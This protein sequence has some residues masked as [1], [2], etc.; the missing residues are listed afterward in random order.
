MFITD[1][2]RG[3]G[4]DYPYNCGLDSRYPHGNTIRLYWYGVNDC[5]GYQIQMALPIKVANGA[6]A[7]ANVQGTPDLLLDTIVGPDKLDL[8]IE[9]LQYKTDYRFAIR[10]LDERDAN[11]KGDPNS[12]AHASNWFGHGNGR[13]W[14]EFM[15]IQ[16]KDR[17]ATPTAIFVNQSLTTE[18]TIT[19]GINSH[20]MDMVGALAEVSGIAEYNAEYVAA[21]KAKAK[22]DA[23]AGT[24]LTYDRLIAE[25]P[26]LPSTRPR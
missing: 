13:Q 21:A 7:W 15:N 25:F 14:Q 20:V 9:N 8:V 2:T 24:P 1:N 19:V 10:A 18:H 22:A 17:Y 11:N 12:F 16:T 23:A 26:N 3:K 5:A 6:D 4:D